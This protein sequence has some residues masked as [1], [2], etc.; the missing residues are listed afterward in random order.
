MKKRIA[1]LTSNI[2]NPFLVSLAIIWLISF[3][4]TS[5]TVDAIKWALISMALSVVPVFL[6]LVYLTRNGKL[7]SIFTNVRRQRTKVY[8]LASLCALA[9]FIVLYYLR[10]PSLLV[11]A[12]TAGLSAIVI[13]MCVNLWWKI[14]L[15]T[16]FIAASVTVL[17]VLYGWIATISVALVPLIAW[18]R[19]EQKHHSPAQAAAGALLAALV[20]VLVFYSFAPA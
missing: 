2:L 3:T 10:A 15:H 5:S 6:V 9:G 11:A 13:F 12:F 1:N 4:A 19:I 17:V 7:D 14:S 16:A 20:V 8:L 18:A